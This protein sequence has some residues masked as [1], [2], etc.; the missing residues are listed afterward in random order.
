MIVPSASSFM[1]L[2]NYVLAVDPGGTK[3]DALLAD[4]AGTLVAH[5]R[6][7]DWVTGGRHPDIM[8]RAIRQVLY[9]RAPASLRI[10]ASADRSWRPE[11]PA[12]WRNCTQTFPASEAM[13]ALASAGQTFGLVV[14]AGTGARVAIRTRTGR[15]ISLDT[16]GPVL[17][18]SGSGYYI[19][20]EAL[21]A[22]SREIQLAR[23]AT[24]LRRRVLR[25]CGCRGLA[26]LVQFSLQT[27][28]RS[29][30]A[31]LSKIVDEEACAGDRLA[32]RLLRD[33][34][35]VI[36][37]TVRDL[38]QHFGL[39]GEEFPLV[40]AGSVATHSNIYWREFCRQVQPIV[41]RS[42]LIRVIL[43]PV[44]GLAAHGLNNAVATAKLFAT[45][46][47]ELTK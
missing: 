12:E 24:R 25:A 31:S 42:K 17:G 1:K 39:A 3:C 10:V 28:D 26:A 7:R 16:L 9:R 34:A 21:R 2:F 38:V 30:I 29:R 46:K 8:R 4:A 14:I 36:A 15:E 11:L 47:K 45:L 43:P 41:P 22:L 37:G 13:S 18:D 27:R 23:P 5:C 35:T 19:G 32:Q 33:A 6:L 44:A 20:R 40:G